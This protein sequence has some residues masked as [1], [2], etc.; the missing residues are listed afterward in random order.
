MS[1]AVLHR[2][3]LAGVSGGKARGEANGVALRLDGEALLE[4]LAGDPDLLQ[5]VFGALL[6]S[7]RGE[8]WVRLP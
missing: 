6:E 8:P 1:D 7:A 4:I 3:A 5:G 2:R